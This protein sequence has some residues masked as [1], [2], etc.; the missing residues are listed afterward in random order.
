MSAPRFEPLGDD[1]LLVRFGDTIDA[2]TNA[3]VHGLTARLRA[4]SPPW[5]RDAVPAYASLAVF[6]DAARLR[7]D[8]PHATVVD[9]VNRL[10][11][12]AGAGPV[13]DGVLHE[14]PVCYGGRHGEDLASAAYELGLDEATLIARHCAPIYTVAMIGFAPGFPYLLGLDP[15]LALPRLA[16]PRTRV[17]A[18]AV[19]IGGAQAGIYPRESPGGW[20]L[21]GRTPQVL[22]DVR[23]AQPS[24]LQPGDRV[25]FVPIDDAA[26]DRMGITA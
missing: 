23:R 19:A 5:L 8:D 20:R 3:R 15:A 24:L 6:F 1:A 17:P 21:L 12:D 4:L 26:F 18:G 10:L 9:A 14:I 25:R 16:T 7:G 22:F 13:G 11:S 2:S